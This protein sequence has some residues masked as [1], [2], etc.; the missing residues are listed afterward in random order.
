MGRPTHFVALPL[1]SPA[2]HAGMAA[3]QDRVVAH[4]P[5]VLSRC[6][7][8]PAKAHLTLFVLEATTPERV[9]AAFARILPMTHKIPTYVTMSLDGIGPTYE[10][11]RGVPD[12][13]DKVMRSM[14]ILKR[15]GADHPSFTTSFQIT[16]SELNVH[17]ADALFEVA[18]DGHERPIVTMATDALQ[19]TGGKAD[20]DVRSAGPEVRAALKLVF[21]VA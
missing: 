21:R 14:D 10:R 17:E 18:S 20:I 2:L 12:G 3:L 11:V 1:P 15:L 4:L 19:L 7:V 6:V 13:Y 8:P 16:L 5:K 9:E